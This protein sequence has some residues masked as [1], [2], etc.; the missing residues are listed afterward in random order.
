[1]AV[2]KI[3]V[4]YDF[5]KIA[6]LQNATIQ[7]LASAPSS[8][9]EGQLYYDTVVKKLYWWNG[10]SWID[11]TGGAVP[12]DA[13][14]TV[15]GV[16]RL[17]V[18]PVSPTIPI[19]MGDNDPRG[20]DNRTPID[21]SVTPTKLKGSPALT[22]GQPAVWDGTNWIAGDPLSLANGLKL[23]DTTVASGKGLTFGAADILLWR[24][25]PG[26]LSWNKDVYLT[27]TPTPGQAHFN[28]HIT[29]DTH[30]VLFTRDSG[31]EGLNKTTVTI[32]AA[33][34]GSNA[35]PVGTTLGVSGYELAHGTIKAVHFKPGTGGGSTTTS[36]LNAAVLS[37]RVNGTG[38]EAQY[39]FGDSEDS[40]LA[41]TVKMINLRSLGVEKFVVM[42]DGK[43]YSAGNLMAVE[44][45][46]SITNL[47]PPTGDY[48]MGSKRWTNMLDPLSPQDG[49]TKNYV[50]LAIAGFTKASVRVATTANITIS[51]ALN[52][53]DVIDGVT[54]AN[55][56]FVL[57]KNQTATQE[58]GIYT[59]S[60]SPA[61]STQANT[62]AEIDGL[63]VLVEDGTQ[64]GTLWIST[65]DVTT[66]GTDPIA[67]SQF[68]KAT[69]LIAGA[70]LLATGL[71]WDVQVDGSS[72]EVFS[73]ALRV[74]ALG[75]TNAMIAAATIDLTTKVTGQ[76]PVANGG[77]GQNTAKLAR[78]SG[79]SAAG[80]YSSATHGAGASIAIT[81]A[82]HGLRASRG[83]IVQNQIESTGEI[84]DASVVVAASG[85]VTVTF[86]TSQSANTIRTTIIG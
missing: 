7:N 73:D 41:A 69:D 17:S 6:E 76:L 16:T 1:M 50:D 10:T 13:S 39:I 42:A 25:G 29:N 75:I 86:N 43:V 33:D 64:G 26:L 11:A 28:L 79:L 23:T 12:S 53:G 66:L 24:R 72:L 22:A 15:K 59:V 82:T 63:M 71:T 62:A 44:G 77:T 52:S 84:V 51:T 56:D 27:P 61:R 18:A 65:S 19:A 70:A 2:K 49:A 74:K 81:Q 48:S 40:A 47:L 30:G 21:G 55:G 4:H 80:Y 9:V 32:T 57:V 46:S 36:D 3:G 85:D 31:A 5:Q 58:N 68:N 8:P 37:L 67:F 54:L 78:E 83:L 38:T 45:V 34:T 20:S 60:A 35:A 14:T